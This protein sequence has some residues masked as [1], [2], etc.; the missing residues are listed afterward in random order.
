MTIQNKILPIILS[1]GYGTRLWPI[2]R[3]SFPKQYLNLIENNHQSLLQKTILRLKDLKDI[4]NPMILC[5]E[6]HRFI[7]AEQLR[8]IQIKPK[9]ILLEPFGRNTAPAITLASLKATENGEDPILIILPSDHYIKDN[10]LFLESLNEGIEFARQDRL[11]TFGI[12]PTSPETGFGYIKAEEPIFNGK[13]KSSNIKEFIEKPNIEL[14][15]KYIEDKRF[16]W[17]SGIFVFKA[18][19]I[20]RELKRFFPELIEHCKNA[21]VDKN[22]DMDFQRINPE[23]FKKCLN[24]SIDN[25][26]MEKTTLGTVLPLKTKWSDLGSW[27]AIWDNSKKDKN[28]NYLSSNLIIDDVKN[29]FLKSDNRLIVAVG[30]KDLIVVDTNDATL[31]IDKNQINKIKSIVEKL[32]EKNIEEGKRHKKVYRPWGHFISI[33]EGPNWKVKRIE[34]NPHEKLSLQLHKYRAE[35]WIIV[36][37]TAEIQVEESFITLNKNQSTFIP[38]GSKHRLSNPSSESLILIEVQSGTYLGEDDIIRFK[39]EYNRLN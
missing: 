34:V 35:H 31:I 30:I 20:K 18:S 6:E 4:D 38:I 10:N 16:A 8:Q 3:E 5:N 27:E 36:E 22:F 33:E 25:A 14:A 15:L 1:G 21:I 13:N 26:I 17:N 11:V 7:A 28:N 2:S 19:A 9:L 32:N 24:I 39:D 29:C 23:E 37:G 12:L